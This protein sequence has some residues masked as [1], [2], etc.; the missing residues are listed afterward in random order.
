MIGAAPTERFS[1]A[2]DPFQNAKS[3]AQPVRPRI[4]DCKPAL[5]LYRELSAS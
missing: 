3:L 2:P 5:Y 1:P 4:L